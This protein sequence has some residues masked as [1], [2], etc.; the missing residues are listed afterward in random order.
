[1]DAPVWIWAP[2]DGDI[3]P[4]GACAIL[5]PLTVVAP[6]TLKGPR[7]VDPSDAGASTVQPQ[8]RQTATPALR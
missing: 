2:Y 5:G 1:M 8:D 7:A 3:K 6:L 4:A